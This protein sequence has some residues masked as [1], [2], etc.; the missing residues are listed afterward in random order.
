MSIPK[1]YDF[2]YYAGD[3]YQLVLYPRNEDGSQYDL[4]NHTSLFTVAT[5][6]GN[7]EAEVFS[8]S[9]QLSASP[10]RMIVTITPEFGSLLDEPSYVYDIEL[11][12]L[13]D[14]EEVYTFVTGNI[15]VQQQVTRRTLEQYQNPGAL[16]VTDRADVIIN[17]GIPTSVFYSIFDGGTP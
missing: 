1:E 14:P 15:N 10:S 16:F 8:A 13:S 4:S 7:P 3:L 9:V 5:E 11:V 2:N 17:G 6:R 12:D